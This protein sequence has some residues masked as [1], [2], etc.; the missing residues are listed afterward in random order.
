[1]FAIPV[2]VQDKLK[3]AL[4]DK[5]GSLFSDENIPDPT[6][7][8]AQPDAEPTSGPSQQGP[9]VKSDQPPSSGPSQKGPVV[10]SSPTRV[11]RSSKSPTKPSPPPRKRRFLQKISDSDS[12]EEPMKSPPVQKQRKKIRPTIIADLT[13]D[14]PRSEDPHQA[15]VPFSNQPESADPVLIEP[16]SAIP[17]EEPGI[18]ADIPMLETTS[19]KG[20][21]LAYLYLEYQLNSDKKESK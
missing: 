10:K 1:M 7:S 12:E 11:L 13:V 6:S 4:P 17:I 20:T 3:L 19:M 14:P 8:S 9:V 5:Y 21:C 16:I 15:L 2:T 18:A